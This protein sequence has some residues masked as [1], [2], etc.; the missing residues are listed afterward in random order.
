MSHHKLYPSLSPFNYPRTSEVYIN[1]FLMS[2]ISCPLLRWATEQGGQLPR[3]A[4][5][6]AVF[7][8]KQ[9]SAFS[10]CSLSWQCVL[11]SQK[12]VFE[13]SVGSHTLSLKEGTA[14]G[15]V[16]VPWNVSSSIRDWVPCG[17]NA[18]DFS[19]HLKPFILQKNSL[20]SH[21]TLISRAPW[22]SVSLWPM[23]VS[24]ALY[25]AFGLSLLPILL[26]LTPYLQINHQSLVQSLISGKQVHRHQNLE[27]KS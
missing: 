26:F 20:G 19:P 7:Y 8:L 6:S 13:M 25:S 10:V 14:S 1:I 3:H 12:S 22:G 15:D 4:D 27:T 23:A 21:C 11:G 5:S 17:E 18:P 9:R 24:W 16:K 2:H